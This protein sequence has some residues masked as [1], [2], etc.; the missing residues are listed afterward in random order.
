MPPSSWLVGKQ[1]MP[2]QRR[3]ERKPSICG[4]GK[5]GA[6]NVSGSCSGA[7]GER[8]R[9]VLNT[10][11]APARNQVQGPHV[12]WDIVLDH[13]L[14]PEPPLLPPESHM[15]QPMA[16]NSTTQISPVYHG[17][18]HPEVRTRFFIQSTGL[19]E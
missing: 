18:A 14:I 11:R 7:A 12:A 9:C 13:L 17:Q 15:S 8:R 1:K 19:C 2:R 6:V 5:G 4:G 10:K 16:L 3:E